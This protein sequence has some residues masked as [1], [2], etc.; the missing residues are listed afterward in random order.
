MAVNN[1]N[2]EICPGSQHSNE[3]K[4]F[5]KIMQERSDGVL[6]QSTKVPRQILKLKA[7]TKYNGRSFSSS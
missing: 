2:P 4:P 7:H 3:M 1:I 6:G 5:A